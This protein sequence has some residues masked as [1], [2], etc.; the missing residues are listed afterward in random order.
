MK[1]IKKLCPNF[2][3]R[4]GYKPEIIVIHISTNTL[5]SMISW[6]NTPSSQAS[7]HY[8]IGKDGTILQYVEES[9]KAWT[10][11]N[12]KNPTAKIIKER[13]GINPNLF[14]LSIE[15]EGQDL[16][17]APEIQL[18]TLCD[19]IKDIA[20]RWNIKIS[21]NTVIGHWEIDSKNRN[22]CP[23]PNHLFMDKLVA[24]LQPDEMVNIQVPKSRLQRIL[25]F[26]MKI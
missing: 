4:E 21:R 24:R 20:S 16:Q 22:Y 14:C 6:F 11:G 25:D 7:A 15:N 17:Y 10:Q 19:L 3:S 12:V 2:S 5:A 13:I 8:G 26:L 18:Q 1:I 23:S 9:N